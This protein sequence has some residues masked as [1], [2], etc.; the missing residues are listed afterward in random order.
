M[1]GGREGAGAGYRP[2]GAAPGT[3]A[4]VHRAWGRVG[5][6]HLTRAR[7]GVA[8]KLLRLLGLQEAELAPTGGGSAV[9]LPLHLRGTKCCF[10]MEFFRS[11][12][13]LFCDSKLCIFT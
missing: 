10:F 13:T 3:P 9:L 1:G 2:V 11:F 5:K 12:W 7:V 6:G 4:P 8:G